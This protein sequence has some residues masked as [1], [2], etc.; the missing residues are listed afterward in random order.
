M[1]GALD[2]GRAARR[3]GPAAVDGLEPHAFPGLHARRYRGESGDGQ[4][5]HQTLTTWDLC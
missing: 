1:H 4:H 2:T 5:S 3:M